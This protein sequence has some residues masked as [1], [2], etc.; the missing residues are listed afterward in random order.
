MLRLTILA[1][2]TLPES[3]CGLR[4]QRGTVDMVFTARQIQEKCREKNK[5]LY[6]G[7]IDL[8]KTFDSVYRPALWLVLQKFGCPEILI[9]MIRL[10]PDGMHGVSSF[11]GWRDRGDVCSPDRSK[12]RMCPCPHFVFYHFR[13][14]TFTCSRETSRSVHLLC[15]LDGKIFN[16]RRPSCLA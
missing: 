15:C 13:C 4:P 5:Y 11:G 1:E 8:S 7:F 10:L 3:H 14:R 2:T 6:A 12:A 9:T 16:L